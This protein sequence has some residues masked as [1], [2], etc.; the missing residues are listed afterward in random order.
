MRKVLL[1][2]GLLL[3]GPGCAHGPGLWQ[4]NRGGAPRYS[5]FNITLHCDDDF[6]EATGERI[7]TF[8]EMVEM[9]LAGDP[10]VPGEELDELEEPEGWGVPFDSCDA[11]LQ[12]MREG[13]SDLLPAVK[14]KRAQG[15]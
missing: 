12:T 5:L 4:S 6:E 2:S 10:W 11:L 9:E 1:L 14:Y 13:S 7:P 3:V 15:Y 8:D